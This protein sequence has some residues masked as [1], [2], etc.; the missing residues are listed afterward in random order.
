MHIHK[1]KYIY[2]IYLPLNILLVCVQVRTVPRSVQVCVA[3]SSGL[4]Y[5]QFR[6][7][8]HSVQVC[9]AFLCFCAVPLSDK[10]YIRQSQHV[11]SC[12]EGPRDDS[13][14][15][16]PAP[17]QQALWLLWRELMHQLSHCLL[18][19]RRQ[20][21][22]LRRDYLVCS[23]L[24]FCSATHSHKCLEICPGRNLHRLSVFSQQI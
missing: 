14:G 3:L 9:V 18:P 7:V 15:P 22:W 8:L 21:R 2:I 16:K 10:P 19:H 24:S 4:C 1:Y 13:R 11:R 23:R 20:C 12:A 6:F 5:V 17:P